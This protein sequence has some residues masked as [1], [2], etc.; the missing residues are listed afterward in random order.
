MGDNRDLH[1]SPTRRSCDLAL[2]E[3]TRK[4]LD[5]LSG[6]LQDARRELQ[7]RTLE[8]PSRGEVEALL[9]RVQEALLDDQN[10]I[11]R[12]HV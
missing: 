4:S 2:L 12:A 9:G 7:G 10:K 8:E 3:K 6:V 11:G 1:P 5:R